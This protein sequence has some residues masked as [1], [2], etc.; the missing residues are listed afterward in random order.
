MLNIHWFRRG[1]GISDETSEAVGSD[2]SP[3]LKIDSVG[4]AVKLAFGPTD[5]PN[6]DGPAD[7]KDVPSEGM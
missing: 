2:E 6:L 7:F 1:S 5:G 4:R 3:L